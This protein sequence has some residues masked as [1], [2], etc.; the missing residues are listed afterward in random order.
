MP[1]IDQA[2]FNFSPTAGIAVAFMVG[3]LVFAVALDLKWDQFRRV[4]QAPKAPVIGLVGQFVLLPAV[5]FVVG[6]ILVDAPSI[7]LG[8]LLVACCPGGALSNYFTAVAKG[9]VAT[10]VSM[11]AASTVVCVVATPLVFGFWASIN[12]STAALL[13]EIGIDAKRVLGVLMIMVVIPVSLGMLLCAK[14]PALAAKMRRP[15]RRASMTV[16]GAVVVVVLGMNL[17][18]LL[19]YADDALVPVLLTFTLAASLGWGLARL[20]RL[21]SAQRRAITLEIAM[22][23]VGLALGTAV[24]FFPSL[25]GVAVT[26][27]LWGVVHL[28]CGFALAASWPRTASP[29]DEV[30]T[31]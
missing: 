6:W 7:T 28:T 22:Q 5:A 9:D 11:T 10:S 21:G 30:L 17:N 4:V 19:D 23:N 2:S 16:F 25:V 31:A 8:L 24:A 3:F 29:G 20:T 15:V 18:L 27:A 1:S 12:P 13:H 26:C 14:R